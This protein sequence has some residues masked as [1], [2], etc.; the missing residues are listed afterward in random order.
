MR[1][2]SGMESYD[3]GDEAAPDGRYKTQFE[4]YIPSSPTFGKNKSK[5]KKSI[6]RNSVDNPIE[7]F[8]DEEFDFNVNQYSKRSM[9][10]EG[11]QEQDSMQEAKYTPVKM[12]FA[13]EARE[14]KKVDS[15]T[16]N[17]TSQSGSTQLVK[18]DAT[19]PSV[20]SALK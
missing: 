12:E 3:M 19:T 17:N 7:P 16:V 6:R 1:Q 13:R 14:S 10:M 2:E 20:V 4:K 9:S 18:P 5:K 8:N 11:Y 15:F